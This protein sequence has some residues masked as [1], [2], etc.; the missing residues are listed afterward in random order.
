[1]RPFD[2]SDNNFIFTAPNQSAYNPGNGRLGFA[3]K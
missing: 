2:S 3:L 1:M